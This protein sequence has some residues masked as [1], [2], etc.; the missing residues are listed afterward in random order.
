VILFPAIDLKG[1]K[2]V[3]LKR[4]AMA[5]ATVFGEDP[6][7]QARAFAAQ[8]FQWLHVVDLDGAFAGESL[9]RQAIEAILGAT[10]LNVQLGGGIRSLEAI[11]GWLAAGVRRVILGTAAVRDPQLVRS[12]ARTF[13]GRIAIAID[14]R[15]GRVA[16]AG[17]AETSHLSAKELARR[18]ED[19]GIA[20]LLYTDIDRDG[21]LAGLDV[22]AAIDLARRVSVPVI[23]GGGLA[24]L[25]D[26]ERLLE[27]DCRRL[28]GAIAGRALYDGSLD[29]AEAL[30][31]I[32]ASGE[33]SASVEDQAHSLS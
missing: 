5:S 1:G 4:G 22:R 3:R 25:A 2:C 24:S 9:N 17:W 27:P 29:G 33:V 31:R 8:G 6:A 21:M 14:A 7:G 11:E 18:Y 23:V 32:A 10:P 12:A 28:L 26:V 16:V 30:R 13:P 15:A 19:S 20:A